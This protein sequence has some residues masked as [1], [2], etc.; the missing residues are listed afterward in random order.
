MV[1]VALPALALVASGCVLLPGGGTARPAYPVSVQE[2]ASAAKQARRHAT[3]LAGT[4]AA[5]DDE[6]RRLLDDRVASA[7]N[8]L[9]ALL[10][11]L[12][13]VL[14]VWRPS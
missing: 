4:G 3:E 10:T 8:Y 6:L 9:S 5:A 2:F 12:I 13:I 7:L 14:M 1:R 11:L